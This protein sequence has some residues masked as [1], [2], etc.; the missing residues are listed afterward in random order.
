VILG[1]LGFV[2]SGCC[3]FYPF[4]RGRHG[5][6]GYQDHEQRGQDRGNRGDSPRSEPDRRGH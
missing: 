5:G 6:G 3:G 4:D 2:V 1:A